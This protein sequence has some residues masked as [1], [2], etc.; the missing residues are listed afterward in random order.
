MQKRWLLNLWYLWPLFWFSVVPFFIVQEWTKKNKKEI[1]KNNLKHLM[2][3]VKVNAAFVWKLIDWSRK[4]QIC[5]TV[6]LIE[7]FF[8]V[9]CAYI[10]HKNKRCRRT[11][12]LSLQYCTKFRREKYKLFNVVNSKFSLWN[13]LKR[14]K[15]FLFVSY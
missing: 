3:Y 8:V 10:Y 9:K 1:I 7:F 2:L 4:R 12:I 11:A 5:Y 13:F 15:Q 14:I 6:W